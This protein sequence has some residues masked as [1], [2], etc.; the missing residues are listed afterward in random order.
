[1][2]V[3]IVDDHPVVRAGLRALLATRFEVVGEAADGVEAVRLV[4]ALRPCVV[5]MD[6]QLGDGMDGITATRQ[7]AGQTRVV[8]LTT[9]DTDADVLRAIEAGAAGYLLKEAPP[10]ELF[11]AL[12]TAMTGEVALSPAVASR[13]A[14]RVRAPQI[15][16]S[17]REIEILELIA[18]GRSNRD[19][20]RML[21]I[22]EATVK[23]HVK[24]VF[25]KLGV[26]CR[27]AAVRT[28]VD[29]RLIRL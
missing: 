22:S 8:V 28:A 25:N 19:I 7:I 1:M 17:A 16:L 15:A 29:R 13:M 5:L 9:Y 6:L 24:H 23:T 12:R 27:T 20:G 10:E 21:F 14:R 3:L 18:A 4:A 11:R 26:D 2:K